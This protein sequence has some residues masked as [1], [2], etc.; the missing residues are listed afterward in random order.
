MILIEN[1]AL[2]VVMINNLQLN[3]DT[4]NNRKQSAKNQDDKQ[5]KH[6]TC[7]LVLSHHYSDM[8]RNET[9]NNIEREKTSQC[10]ET[11]INDYMTELVYSNNRT[12]IMKTSEHYDSDNQQN[13]NLN[14]LSGYVE[15]DDLKNKEWKTIHKRKHKMN[16]QKTI[17]CTG[18]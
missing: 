10:V 3:N 14:S 2:L 6:Q 13:M 12:N 17:L 11:I 1:N 4:E 15:K 16:R 8:M 7:A 5:Y 18:A 9:E